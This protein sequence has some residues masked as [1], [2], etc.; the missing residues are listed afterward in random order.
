M[1]EVQKLVTQLI[2]N[3]NI[4]TENINHSMEMC[5]NW[6]KRNDVPV[7]MLENK[8]L[9]M[10]VATIGEKGPTIVLNGHIDVVPGESKDF[11]PRI[12][13]GKIYGRGSYDMLGS[14]AVM[15]KVMS[16]LS[17][18]TLNCKVMLVIVPDEETGGNIGTK[19]LVENGYLGDMVICGEPT[20][21]NVALQSKGFLQLNLTFSGV[22]AHGS[23]PWL[24]E[25]AILLAFEKYQKFV[26]STIPYKK[27]L[28]FDSH[29]FNLAKI[30][31]GN[32]MNQ[33][34]NSCTVGVDIRYM[35]DQH[36]NDFL[37]KIKEIDPAVEIDVIREG[38]PV[39]TDK[40]NRFVRDLGKSI[41]SVLNNRPEFFGQEGASDSR[42]YATHGI[43]TVE[44]GPIGANHHG[45][46]EYVEIN[47][48]ARYK[49]IL[50]D[51]LSAIK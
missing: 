2:K 9:K 36:P 6:L 26:T 37:Q 11:V 35:P 7:E 29:S 13:E 5:F 51:Y 20:N 8:G 19:Y 25:N 17:N 34:P 47:S 24:G 31:G 3:K 14:V 12:L 41:E 44:F 23:R 32:A 48:L 43:P 1:K 4:T 39:K 21:L 40:N 16:E 50:I 46:N 28:F 22:S 38:S 45:P 30:K 49:N 18:K 10:I 15:M 27:T 42:F 33:V